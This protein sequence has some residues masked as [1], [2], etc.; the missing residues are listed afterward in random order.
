M[1]DKKIE[2][3]HV[4]TAD[5]RTGD[6]LLGCRMKTATTFNPWNSKV[7]SD[8]VPDARDPGYYVFNTL[9]SEGREYME[10]RVGSLTWLVER[11]PGTTTSKPTYTAA[12]RVIEEY[13][14]NC[15]RCGEKAYVGA[16]KVAHK[17][18]ERAV[19][20]PAWRV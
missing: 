20:C 1:S 3:I 10:S 17:N 11:V 8:P 13:P 16:F 5:L 7:L 2:Q 4:A 18:E 12:P 15:P 9:T 6:K 14:G 19:H